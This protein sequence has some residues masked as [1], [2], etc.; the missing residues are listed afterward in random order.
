MTIS[1][2]G[3]VN[4]A[5]DLRL[6]DTVFCG[7]S[8][9]VHASGGVS[10]PD[11]QSR[12]LSKFARR[13][14]F[15]A[16]RAAL[17][18]TNHVGVV[19][20]CGACVQVARFNAVSVIALVKNPEAFRDRPVRK[21]VGDPMCRVLSFIR[22]FKFA[23]AVPSSISPPKPTHWGFLNFCPKTKSVGFAIHD[24]SIA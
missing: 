16:K 20:L 10:T 5:T 14:S 15:G 21:R 9:L 22:H 6:S 17:A 13:L 2:S 11:G 18:V 4:N 1:P 23:V 19:L 8:A 3:A 24:G 7:K 12:F